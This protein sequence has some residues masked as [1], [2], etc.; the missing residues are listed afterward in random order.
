[1]ILYR[2]RHHLSCYIIIIINY[3]LRHGDRDVK[4]GN[5]VCHKIVHVVITYR[6]IKVIMFTNRKFGSSQKN[7]ERNVFAYVT[8]KNCENSTICSIFET[9]NL[10]F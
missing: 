4:N 9:M 8:T 5:A 10:L 2:Y 6:V 7:V 1:M 3:K